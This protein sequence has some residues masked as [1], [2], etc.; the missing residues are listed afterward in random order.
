MRYLSFA[1]LRAAG[2]VGNRMTLSRWI[3]TQGFPPGVLIGPNTRRWPVEE[4]EA[5]L[6]SRRAASAAARAPDVQPAAAR[7]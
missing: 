7:A 6:E 2:I 4:I 1:D 5:W 3:K